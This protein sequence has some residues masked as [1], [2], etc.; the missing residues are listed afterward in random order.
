MVIEEIRQNAQ[1]SGDLNVTKICNMADKER[2]LQLR[3][4]RE[5]VLSLYARI[6]ETRMRNGLLIEQSLEQIRHTLDMIGRIPA[7]KELYQRQGG[8]APTGNSLG[9][10]RRL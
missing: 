9:L 10:D 5:T 1:Y 3:H 7:K 8:L 2:S 6:E 4:L